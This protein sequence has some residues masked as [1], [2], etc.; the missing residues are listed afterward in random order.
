M[1]LCVHLLCGCLISA[2]GQAA[3]GF[4]GFRARTD[5]VQKGDLEVQG[6]CH[7]PRSALLAAGKL[8]FTGALQKLTTWKTKE[9]YFPSS[10]CLV[11]LT[12]E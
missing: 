12:L 11:P 10:P 4:C 6:V 3:I 2:Q 5:Q 7:S 8:T 9:M 1:Q